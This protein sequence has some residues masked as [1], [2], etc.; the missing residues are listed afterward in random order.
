MHRALLSLI[1]L[2]TA[3]PASAQIGIYGTFSAAN[4]RLPNTGWQY[5]STFGLY[6]NRWKVPFFALGVDGRGSVIGGTQASIAS[7]LVGPRL[8][9]KPHVLPIMPYVE[10]LGGVG[11]AEYGEGSAAGS[12]TKFEYNFVGGVDY[13]VLPRI[14]WRVVDFSYGGLTAFSGSFN[15]RTIST[16]IVFRIP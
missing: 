6:D 9:F 1:L 7:G 10:A 15:P 2:G 16:G 14:D 11:H 13:T 5:G 4:F 12:A 8:V 3:I